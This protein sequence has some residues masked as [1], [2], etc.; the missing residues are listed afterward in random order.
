[1]ATWIQPVT[2]RTQADVEFARNNPASVLL[3]KGA[4]NAVDWNRIAG[5]IQYLS[6]E[7][8]GRALASR[9]NW[10]APSELMKDSDKLQLRNDLA[11]VQEIHKQLTAENPPLPWNTYEKIN[12]VERIL[13]LLE[14]LYRQNAE[15]RHRTTEIYAG[16]EI[17]VL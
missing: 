9:Y 15:S 4:I 6:N 10:Q 13:L 2:D 12:T 5:N 11:T 16:Q 8:L 14:N 7:Y 17:G 1:M 3:L